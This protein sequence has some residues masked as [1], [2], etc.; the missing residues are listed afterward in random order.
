[1]LELAASYG[2]WLSLAQSWVTVADRNEVFG[3]TAAR[4]YKL[5]LA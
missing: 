2:E 4:F 1:V 3:Q 5:E